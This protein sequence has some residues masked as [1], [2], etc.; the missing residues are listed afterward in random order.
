[1]SYVLL[2]TPQV[3]VALHDD[4]GTVQGRRLGR[5]VQEAD[6]PMIPEPSDTGV[7]VLPGTLRIPLPLAPPS[8]DVMVAPT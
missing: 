6:A 2:E 7:R 3:L 5:R 1:M 4:G 8:I